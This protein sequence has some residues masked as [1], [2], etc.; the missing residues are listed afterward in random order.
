MPKLTI[1][2]WFK[3]QA[4]EAAKFYTSVFPNSSIVTVAHYPDAG[5]EITGQ[6]PGSVMT[7]EFNLDGQPFLALNGGDAGFSFNESISFIIDC[8]TQEDI[9][10]YWDA[11]TADGGQEVQ[12]GWLKDKYGV[13]WQVVPPILDQLL[14]DPDKDKANRVMEAMLKMK[15]IVIANLEAAANGS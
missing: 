9:D 12:C 7:V 4:E 11:L 13:A 10:H 2:L 8:E 1:N 15:K 14:S 6:K 3:D 5:Q